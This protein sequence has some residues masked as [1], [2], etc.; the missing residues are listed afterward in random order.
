[1]SVSLEEGRG[2]SAASMQ[3]TK[4]GTVVESSVD[5]FDK[6]DFD[7]LRYINDLF[8]SGVHASVD[9]LLVGLHSAIKQLLV[10]QCLM[11]RSLCN[12]SQSC[13]ALVVL[14]DSSKCFLQSKAWQG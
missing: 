9:H 2:P 8:P 13:T 10:T 6:D 11:S 14:L 3:P 12:G 1:M 7:P 5:A 4:S